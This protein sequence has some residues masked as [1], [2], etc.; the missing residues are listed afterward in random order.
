MSGLQGVILALYTTNDP[1]PMARQH[2]AFERVN[3]EPVACN[4]VGISLPSHTG[5]RSAGAWRVIGEGDHFAKILASPLEGRD[6][7]RLLCEQARFR[8]VSGPAGG[9]SVLGHLNPS[10][11]MVD[12]YDLNPL[13]R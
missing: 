13:Y 8:Q 4:K 2:R 7:D 9:V 5:V 12:Q 11:V 1:V 10:S 6:G 3:L